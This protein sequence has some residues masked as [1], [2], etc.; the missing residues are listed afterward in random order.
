[1]MK[2]KMMENDRRSEDVRA[3]F[4]VFD[5][6]QLTFNLDGIFCLSKGGNFNLIGPMCKF[7]YFMDNHYMSIYC[8]Y[9]Y[10]RICSVSLVLGHFVSVSLDRHMSGLQEAFLV[11]DFQGMRGIFIFYF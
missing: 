2:K 11:K 5:Q 10:V 3:A 6:V 1:M 4:Q 8:T 9:K 7:M